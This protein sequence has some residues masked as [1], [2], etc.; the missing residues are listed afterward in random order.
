VLYA[1]PTDLSIRLVVEWPDFDVVSYKNTLSGK[2]KG[3]AS[4]VCRLQ[5]QNMIEE[6]SSNIYRKH[7]AVTLRHTLN[8]LEKKYSD[9]LTTTYPDSTFELTHFMS[10]QGCMYIPLDLYGHPTGTAAKTK[11]EEMR[12][13]YL[14]LETSHKLMSIRIGFGWMHPKEH[15]PTH[16]SFRAGIKYFL[17][18][19]RD[20]PSPN[21]KFGA[22]SSSDPLD[23][24]SGDTYE[25]PTILV[26]RKR[27]LTRGEQMIAAVLPTTTSKK[28]KK[29]ARCA[30][31]VNIDM[32]ESSTDSKFQ[33]ILLEEGCGGGTQV[34]LSPHPYVFPTYSPGH[35]YN[36]HTSCKY[37]GPSRSIISPHDNPCPLPTQVCYRDELRCI[38]SYFIQGGSYRSVRQTIPHHHPYAL[39]LC[40]GY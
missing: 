6:R 7:E 21:L 28:P 4:F 19:P 2:H 23:T 27:P 29:K 20:S 18:P 37:V 25:L 8:R 24:V 13:Q 35:R 9:F 5:L 11:I 17:C 10:D 38:C 32:T 39:P 33:D 40:L 22:L 16:R 1:G 14:A 3:E 36:P 34:A 12:A 31:P 15:D 26:P 30:T